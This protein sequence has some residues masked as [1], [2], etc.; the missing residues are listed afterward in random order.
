VSDTFTTGGAAITLPNP[1]KTNFNFAGWYL[2]AALTTLVGSGGSSYSPVGTATA[3]D[4]YAKWV[5]STGAFTITYDGNGGVG[6]TVDANTYASGASATILTNNFVSAYGAFI[7]WNTQRNGTGTSYVPGE[8]ITISSSLIL[9]AQW[10]LPAQSISFLQPLPMRVGNAVQVLEAAATSGLP[11][12]YQS[13]TPSVCSIVNGTRLN[14]VNAI[15]A[16]SCT[17]EASQLGNTSIAAANPISLTFQVLA[18]NDTRLI[19]VL[20]PNGGSFTINNQTYYTSFGTVVA[21]GTR[22]ALPPTKNISFNNVAWTVGDISGTAVTSPY[23][24]AADTI[25]VAKWS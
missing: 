24:V 11:I 22:Y 1:G 16:G 7:N 23:T 15:T 3:I 6:S 10:N 13:L 8:A 21:A 25:L 2:D 5:S 14:Y 19:L 4:L 12:T 20:D 9:Y 17:V 18:A